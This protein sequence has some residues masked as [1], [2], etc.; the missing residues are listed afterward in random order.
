MFYNTVVLRG[1]YF[2]TGMRYQ[3]YHWSLAKK[4]DNDHLQLCKIE[5]AST[6]THQFTTGGTKNTEAYTSES[7]KG[8][9]TIDQVADADGKAHTCEARYSEDDVKATATQTLTVLS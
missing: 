2:N 4:D 7:T 6:I 3:W 1:Y 5:F 9:L 8:T